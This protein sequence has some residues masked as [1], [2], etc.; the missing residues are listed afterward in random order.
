MHNVLLLQGL[1]IYAEIPGKGCAPAAEDLLGCWNKVHW[2]LRSEVRSSA[3]FKYI[4]QGGLRLTTACA[5]CTY[6]G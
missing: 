5:T 2:L 6:F 3:E 1:F 4:G